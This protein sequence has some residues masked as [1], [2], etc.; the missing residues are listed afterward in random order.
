MAFGNEEIGPSSWQH[1]C[2]SKSHLVLTQIKLAFI[3]QRSAEAVH[4]RDMDID[5]AQ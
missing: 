2:I 1:K 4:G 5:N 3:A